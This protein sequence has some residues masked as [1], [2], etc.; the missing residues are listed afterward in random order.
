MFAEWSSILQQRIVTCRQNQSCEKNFLALNAI[1][2]QPRLYQESS[3]NFDGIQLCC[4]YCCL[5]SSK[6]DAQNF[7]AS[8]SQIVLVPIHRVKKQIGNNK[9]SVINGILRMEHSFTTT[10]PGLVRGKSCNYSFFCDRNAIHA[11]TQS[12]GR[13]NK[14]RNHL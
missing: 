9:F 12:F 6:S 4:F 2:L 14:Q 11:P 3:L 10:S 8:C 1:V 7:E 5:M 13:H